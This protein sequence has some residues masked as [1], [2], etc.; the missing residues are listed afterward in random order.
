MTTPITE[1]SLAAP[2]FNGSDEEIS[3]AT[4]A[5]ASIVSSLTYLNSAYVGNGTTLISPENKLAMLSALSVYLAAKIGEC[6]NITPPPEVIPF[7]TPT[8]VPAP[9]VQPEVDSYAE[10]L[11]KAAAK[12]SLQRMR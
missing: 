10:D 8:V 2:T 6:N 3:G 4:S 5:W 12:S 7:N 11:K 1:A 9:I